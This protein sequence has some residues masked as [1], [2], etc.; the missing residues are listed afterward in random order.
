M[1]VFV[2]HSTRTPLPLAVGPEA[3]LL[4]ES[5]LRNSRELNAS[6]IRI[7]WRHGK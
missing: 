5:A 6:V 3:S 2:F 7:D 4:T 1:V